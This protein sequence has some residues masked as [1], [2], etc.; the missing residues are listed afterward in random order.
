MAVSAISLIS[1]SDTAR[2]VTAF[3]RDA[4]LYAMWTSQSA[5]AACCRVLYWR[6]HTGGIGEEITGK[7]LKPYERPSAVV[8]TNG[9]LVVAYSD[10]MARGVIWVI[11]FNL[12]TGDVVSDPIQV[13][14]G[15]T[16]SLLQPTSDKNRITMAYNRDD[17]AHL[18]ESYDGGITWS[19][20][21]PVLNAKVSRCTDIV[22]VQFDPTHLSIG[23][24]GE[25]TK[26]FLEVGSFTRTRP[27]QGI[28]KHPTLT[29]RYFVSEPSF[30]SSSYWT[31]FTRGDLRVARDGSKLF[32]LDGARQGTSDSYSEVALL[33]VSADA[34]ALVTSIHND[35]VDGTPGT[36]LSVYNIPFAAFDGQVMFGSSPV[37]GCVGMDVS[38]SY[39]YVVGTK[40]VAPTTNGGAFDVLQISSLDRASVI[41]PN[42]TI[43]GRAVCVGMPP[44]GAPV[45]VVGT[46]ESGV[47]KIR[48]YS[49]NGMTPTL[50]GSHDMPM[51]VNKIFVEMDSATTGRIYVSMTDRLNCYHLNGLTRPLRL[52]TSFAPFAGNQ[53]YQMT[54]TASGNLI[55]ACG[56]AGI[57]IY[58]DV[59]EIQAQLR[60]SSIYAKTWT[61]STV[62]SV[63][64][65][66]T[67]TTGHLYAYSRVYYR[68]TTGGTTGTIEPSWTSASTVSDNGVVWTLVGTLDPNVV[69]IEFDSSRRRIYA[70]GTCGGPTNPQGRFWSFSAPFLS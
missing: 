40:E 1:I 15:V 60:P 39:V 46:V 37:P 43:F 45:I 29:D 56:K 66:V 49:E 2:Q 24:I 50:Q 25:D 63:G 4:D 20:E 61:R 67:M 17:T 70:V 22:A 14:V 3:S 21:R 34:P 28:A 65:L 52:G 11:V 5:N 30:V 13:T 38:N 36:N 42:S 55:V 48:I 27:L 23:Q 19:E 44:S 12:L 16:P 26:P 53:F 64:D 7:V 59:G 41:A 54:K 68:C 51:P 57:M 8:R 62:A 9:N 69:G 35:Q 10:S 6:K 31:D 18:R 33:D 32:H 58:N 47:N